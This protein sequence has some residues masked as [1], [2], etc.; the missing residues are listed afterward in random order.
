MIIVLN[1]IIWTQYLIYFTRFGE[2][3]F[4]LIRGI[5]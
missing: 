3:L 5:F 4:R 2:Y 1:A